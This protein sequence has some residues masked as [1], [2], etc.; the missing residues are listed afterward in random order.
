M[1]L[2]SKGFNVSGREIYILRWPEV[3]AERL[4]ECH[5]LHVG[6]RIFESLGMRVSDCQ[7]T[8]S[9]AYDKENYF[10]CRLMRGLSD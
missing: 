5:C 9:V 6:S 7:H 1:V 2:L 10:A 3:G 8:Y 4:V